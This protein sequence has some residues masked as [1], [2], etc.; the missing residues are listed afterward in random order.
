MFQ[1]AGLASFRITSLQLARLSHSEIHGST[2]VCTSP[3]LNA[4]YHVLHRLLVPRHSPCALSNLMPHNELAHTIGVYPG[5]SVLFARGLT[6]AP[7]GDIGSSQCDST[8]ATICQ[9]TDL[10][11]GRFETA[12]EL[13]KRSEWSQRDSNPRHPAC[14]AGALPTELWPPEAVRLYCLQQ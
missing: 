4:A 11:P 1:F 3:R 7:L 10:A 14:K 8:T 5:R 12:S 13:A 9:S 6:L 2:V